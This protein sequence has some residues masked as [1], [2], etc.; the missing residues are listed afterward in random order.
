ML[1]SAPLRCGCVLFATVISFVAC[2]VGEVFACYFIFIFFIAVPSQSG[3]VLWRIHV[4][5]FLAFRRLRDLRCLAAFFFVLLFLFLGV[6]GL[7]VC[8]RALP[9]SSSRRLAPSLRAARFAGASQ[10]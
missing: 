10:R 9:A 2:S 1:L 5:C 3:G 6:P 7:V 8:L 4:V